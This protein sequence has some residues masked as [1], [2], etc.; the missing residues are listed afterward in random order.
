M[1][2][3]LCGLGWVRGWKGGGWVL[4]VSK[5]TRGV[6]GGKG[7]HNLSVNQDDK[8]LIEKR[9]YKIKWEQ[10]RLEQGYAL[11]VGVEESGFDNKCQLYV[12]ERARNSS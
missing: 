9:L 11:M 3:G 6:G 8:H 2:V 5:R 10:E 7:R 12:N 1:G 4:Q